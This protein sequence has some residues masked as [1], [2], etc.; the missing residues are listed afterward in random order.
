[1]SDKFERD[2]ISL[3][4]M[5]YSDDPFTHPNMFSTFFDANNEELK[6][7][8]IL[9]EIKRVASEVLDYKVRCGAPHLVDDFINELQLSYAIWSRISSNI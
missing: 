3:L 8:S 5:C 6:K 4:D 1:M 7:V 2:L 9:E